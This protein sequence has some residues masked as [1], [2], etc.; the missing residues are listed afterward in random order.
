MMQK[1]S[2]YFPIHEKANRPS[3]NNYFSSG[4][5]VASGLLGKLSLAGRS[6]RYPAEF[7]ADRDERLKQS[8]GLS[9]QAFSGGPK[10]G[11]YSPSGD[12]G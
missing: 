2:G 5:D 9:A 8:I 3:P 12:S 6:R 1:R 7:R 11:S 4:R 10:I